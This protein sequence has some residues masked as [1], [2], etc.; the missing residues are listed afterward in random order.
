MVFTLR[1]CAV[2]ATSSCLQFATVTSADHTA[3]RRTSRALQCQPPGGAITEGGAFCVSLVCALSYCAPPLL[4]EARFANPETCVCCTGARWSSS[5]W[6]L[7]EGGA[8]SSCQHF[9]S[10]DC[11][12]R[13]RSK[14]AAERLVCTLSYCAPPLL[15]KA[16]FANPETCVCCTGARRSSSRAKA[17]GEQRL[18]RSKTAADL[19]L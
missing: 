16:R 2:V 4:H 5:R 6:A 3:S 10:S 8:S 14:A 11:A 12:L 17:L 13:L 7:G 15:H 9:G 18:L 19:A 1:T